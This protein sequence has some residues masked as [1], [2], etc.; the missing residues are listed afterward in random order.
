MLIDMQI[1]PQMMASAS[2]LKF[3]S[4][5][6]H[7]ANAHTLLVLCL[8]FGI[9]QCSVPAAASW[10]DRLVGPVLSC[11]GWAESQSRGFLS[12][13]CP[14][15]ADSPSSMLERP[16]PSSAASGMEVSGARS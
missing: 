8:Y 11:M 13:D 14:S 1:K 5:S 6:C 7:K 4:G 9:A 16:S 15:E 10:P 12:C 2:Y 3:T